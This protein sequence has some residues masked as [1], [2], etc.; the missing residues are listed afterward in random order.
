MSHFRLVSWL[1]SVCLKVIA[2]EQLQ[3]KK[4]ANPLPTC[5][6]LSVLFYYSWICICFL[7]RES[8]FLVL[9]EFQNIEVGF[10][11]YVSCV[12]GCGCRNI[13]Q[14]HQTIHLLESSPFHMCDASK[15]QTVFNHS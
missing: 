2:E 8:T 13:I 15:R 12:W 1:W 4:W 14:L 10:F 6:F 3:L 11:F 5:N 9:M 7:S